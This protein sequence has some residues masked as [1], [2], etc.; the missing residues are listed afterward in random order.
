MDMVC[1]LWIRLRGLERLQQ[2]VWSA[3]SEVYKREYIERDGEREREREREIE[4]EIYIY[5]V[6]V[7]VVFGVYEIACVHGSNTCVGY[8]CVLCVCGAL[9]VL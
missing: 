1:I 2:L 5:V 7:Y 9:L 3:E 6:C 4:R 8:V